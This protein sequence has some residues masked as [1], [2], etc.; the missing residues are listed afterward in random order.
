M[1]TIVSFRASSPKLSARPLAV[2]LAAV[3]CALISPAS[4][5]ASPAVE[6]SSV[7]AAA[8]ALAQRSKVNLTYTP[9]MVA[10]THQYTQA[11]AVALAKKFDVIVAMPV[12]FS[13]YVGAMKAANPQLT[14]LAYSNATFASPTSAAGLPE[15]AYAHTARGA[16]ITSNNFNHT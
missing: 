8:P 1:E 5:S 16:R 9:E 7:G 11:E 10:S 15:A 13:K 4:S 14:L 12:S 2:V 6:A 3:A